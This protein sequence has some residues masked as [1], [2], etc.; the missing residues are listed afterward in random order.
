MNK[1]LCCDM[2]AKRLDPECTVFEDEHVIAHVPLHQKPGN[3]GHVS[4]ISKKHIQDIYEL[5][6]ELNAPL[7]AALRLL[8]RAT[9]KAFSA[10][11]IHI[12]QNNEPAAGQTVFHLHFHIIPRYQGD[13]FDAKKYERLPLQKRKELSERLRVAVQSEMQCT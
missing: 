12:R 9:K 6:E 2:V 4:I 1:C 10:E 3:Y 11:G 13:E 5:P 8:S 7:M